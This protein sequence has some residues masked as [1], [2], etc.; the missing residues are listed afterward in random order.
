VRIAFRLL[1]SEG[2]EGLVSACEEI[3]AVSILV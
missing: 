2:L 3:K 1:A